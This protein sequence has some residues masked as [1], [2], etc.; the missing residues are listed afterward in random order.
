MSL[1][2]FMVNH[3]E[4]ERRNRIRLSLAAYAYEFENTSIMSDADFDK[5]AL[6]I[7]PELTTIEEY[8]LPEQKDRYKVL[9]RFFQNEFQPDTG[10]WIHK[11]PELDR[12]ANLYNKLW[13]KK[14][15]LS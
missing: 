1:D 10:Q 14:N 7:N 6:Q 8:Q 5:L 15:V 12:L 13:R 11:H 3:I 4:V 2:D 9:D